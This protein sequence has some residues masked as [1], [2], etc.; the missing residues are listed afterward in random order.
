MAYKKT[1]WKDRVVEKPNTYRSVE[2]PDGTI[3]LYPITGQVIEKGTPVSAA[4]LNKIE[5]GIVELNEQLVTTKSEIDILVPKVDSLASGSPKGV[6]PTLTALQSDIG[7]N[8][9][10]GKKSIYVVSADGGWYYWN[11]TAWVKG[12]IYQ[13]TLSSE[14]SATNI[15][16]NGDF[17]NGVTGGWIAVEGIHS[18]SNNILTLTANGNSRYAMEQIALSNLVVGHK[19]YLRAY[20]SV[21]NDV[22]NQIGL[23]L[24]KS[25]EGIQV[26]A[27][28]TINQQYNIASIFTASSELQQ[29]QISHWYSDSSTAINKSLNIKYVVAF[30]LTATFGR[31]NEPILTDVN[32]IMSYIPNMW[33]AGTR[34]PLVDNEIIYNVMLKIKNNGLAKRTIIGTNNQIVVTSG[35]GVNG[36]PIL[37]IPKNPILMHPEVATATFGNEL[38]PNISLW[39]GLGGAVFSNNK[40]EIPAK[41]QIKTTIDVENGMEY[42]IEINWERTNDYVVLRIP[43]L[44]CSLG[45]VVSPPQFVGYSDALYKLTLTANTTG[46]VDLILGDGLED[47]EATITNVSVRKVIDKVTPAGKLGVGSFDVTTMGSSLAIGSG[48]KKEQ[49]EKII[50]HLDWAR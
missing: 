2:N 19:Y 43:Q 18:V 3:T 15:I 4:N 13:T 16:P 42:Q 1:L 5:N 7:A 41:A 24:V 29:L 25:I 26:I 37:A 12:G 30:D 23:N 38:A 33:W 34:S 49:V 27:N 20:V 46:T 50:V 48:L 36:N 14:F 28:P 6:F 44:I 22:S 10:E 40:W 35:N 21:D 45:E 9:I 47:W 17:S 39:N 32:E 11:G 31:G 8:T